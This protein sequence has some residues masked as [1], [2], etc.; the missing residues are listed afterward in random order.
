MKGRCFWKTAILSLSQPFPFHL[1]YVYYHGIIRRHFNIADEVLTMSCA[2]PMMIKWKHFSTPSHSLWH[3]GN[4]MPGHS[5]RLNDAHT[6]PQKV[7]GHLW[8]PLLHLLLWLFFSEALSISLR[9]LINEV[10]FAGR[11]MSLIM[12][13][14]NL[15]WVWN[16][17]LFVLTREIIDYIATN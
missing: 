13:F 1:C 4:I 10:N 6:P 8:L 7:L 15:Q 17:W 16:I 12:N 14:N 11:S 9:V 3:H 5:L 2:L